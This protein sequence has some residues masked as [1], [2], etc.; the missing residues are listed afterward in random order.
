MGYGAEASSGASGGVALGQNSR[1][2][3]NK[4]VALANSRA[5]GSDSFAAAIASNSSS[6]GAQGLGS[7]SIGTLSKATAL[8]GTAVGYGATSTH[9]A[10]SAFGTSATTTA[11]NQIALGGSGI[12]AR[13]SGAYNLPTSDGTNG[14]VLTTDG[15]GNVTFAAAGGG[16]GAALYAANESS[17]SAQPSATG[18]N[19]I[20]IGDTAVS[21]GTD[22]FAFGKA[23]AIGARSLAFNT[24]TN[25][26]NGAI[27]ADAIAMGEFAKASNSMSIAIGYSS[28]STGSQAV[29]LGFVAYATGNKSIALQRGLASGEDSLTAIITNNT[30]S[31]GASGAN[32][33]AM[34]Y[35]A[36]A[37]NSYA[38]VSGGASNVAS[39]F[40]STVIGGSSNLA[41]NI[42][43][44][45]LGGRYGTTRGIR[46][47]AVFGGYGN[48]ITATQGTSQSG[49]YILAEQT[50]DATA[51]ALKTDN[52]SSSST[53]NQI[54]LPNGGAYAFTGTIVGREAASSGTECAA[55]K[56]EGLIRREANAGSTV[57]VNSSTTVLNNA[58]NWG[59]ALSADTTNGALAITVTGAA[60]TIRWVGTITTTELTFA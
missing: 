21:S 55:W 58:P 7:I 56:V 40:H 13:I 20:A 39:G 29:G 50:T 38:T 44:T 49:L 22:S 19:A 28:N 5:S 12:T 57:L 54:V 34:G 30:S 15:S 26:S 46:G 10:S 23:R 32:S 45:V 53:A 14:Q 9:V 16:G 17:P 47:A 52:Q 48:Q 8:A 59:M 4:A 37:N 18:V 1:S 25:V 31:Y 43:S 42:G 41:D 2:A 24:G 60:K 33:I 3:G 6:Y 27:S 11:T 36:K 51:T 35:L